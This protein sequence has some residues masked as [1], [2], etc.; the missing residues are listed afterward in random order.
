MT[1]MEDAAPAEA[2]SP[3][4]LSP[5]DLSPEDLSPA[6]ALFCV[7]NEDTVL[8]QL[9]HRHE[10]L[11][12]RAELAALVARATEL[13]A[14][15]DTRQ[16]ERLDLTRRQQRYEQ[17]VAAVEARIAELDGKLYG[18]L[19]TSPKEASSLQEEIG[20]LGSRQGD[21]EEQVL[22]IME[23]LEPIEA[24]L[25]DVESG[26]GSN[27]ADQGAVQA[28]LAESEAEVAALT[29]D[30][31]D[32]RASAAA[33]VPSD[34]LARYEGLRRAFGSSVIVRFDGGDC[35]GCP[36]SMPAVEADRVKGLAEG[37]LADCAECGRLVVR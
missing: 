26:I 31:T 3:E 13:T 8:G 5:E 29:A 37:E 9:H 32:R 33:A 27:Q 22:E 12:E 10:H 4:A 7:Q 24:A 15:R 19:I 2:L 14:E 35:R 17:E 23:A 18:G 1:A 28:A 20:H 36:S 11:P 6:E 30:A 25:A 16:I 21:L 34:L